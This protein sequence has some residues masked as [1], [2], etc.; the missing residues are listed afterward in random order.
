MLRKIEKSKKKILPELPRETSPLTNALCFFVSNDSV[1]SYD[2]H[3]ETTFFRGAFGDLLSFAQFS[4]FCNGNLGKY[5][6]NVLLLYGN[7]L[8]ELIL[9][10]SPQKILK[11]MPFFTELTLTPP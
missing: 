4:I 5:C 9:S 10:V 11:N 7:W 3:R 8:N 1:K 2:E 6:S